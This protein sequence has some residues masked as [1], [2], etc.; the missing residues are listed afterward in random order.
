MYLLQPKL[1][2]DIFVSLLSHKEL[3]IEK[4][5]NV[6]VLFDL[7]KQRSPFISREAAIYLARRSNGLSYG[8]PSTVFQVKFGVTLAHHTSQD[9]CASSTFRPL[10]ILKGR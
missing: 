10:H 2:V 7:Q 1:R 9:F 8:S 3:R 5:S 4:K 6:D